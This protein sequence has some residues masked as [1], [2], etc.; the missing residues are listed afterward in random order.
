MSWYWT[1]E[2]S[3]DSDGGVA[4]AISPNSTYLNN[5]IH[6]Y[7]H[8]NAWALGTFTSGA[9]TNWCSGSFS[10]TL[11]TSGMPYTAE[12]LIY[13]STIVVKLPGYTAS[14]QNTLFAT[15]QGPYVFF[16]HGYSDITPSY[17]P[18]FTTIWAG[19]APAFADPIL[20]RCP[21]IPAGRAYRRIRHG[22]GHVTW[23]IARDSPTIVGSGCAGTVT[24]TTGSGPVASAT[25]FTL[26]WPTL[27]YTGAPPTANAPVV[28]LSK[29][30]ANSSGLSG[31]ASPFYS[32]SGSTNA[33]AHDHRQA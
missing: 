25:V 20:S 4:M 18:T 14:C 7:V 21:G 6:F 11:S 26:T 5:A 8:Y 3:G 19:T 1:A 2:S 28:T 33:V 16:E 12:L 27:P 15:Y 30:N 17:V 9:L 22:R 10:P 13:G 23:C 24:F 32:A 31:G 29:C